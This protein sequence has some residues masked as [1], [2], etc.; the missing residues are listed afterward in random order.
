MIRI[1]S[2][3]RRNLNNFFAAGVEKIIYVLDILVTTEKFSVTCQDKRFFISQ[4]NLFNVKAWFNFSAVFGGVTDILKDYCSQHN[5]Q[6]PSRLNIAE[7]PSHAATAIPPYQCISL[8]F[9]VWSPTDLKTTLPSPRR[10]IMW[11]K[12]LAMSMLF[13][14]R[15]DSRDFLVLMSTTSTW[16]FVFNSA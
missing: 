16:P 8:K 5:E 9:G 7:C 3:K 2:T 10:P 6:V 14:K 12:P 15:R 13:L 4:G 1:I 11:W